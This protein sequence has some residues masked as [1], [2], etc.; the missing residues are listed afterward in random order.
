VVEPLCFSVTQR[1]IRP[2]LAGYCQKLPPSLFPARGARYSQFYMNACRVI[3]LQAHPASPRRAYSRPMIDL[4]SVAGLHAHG[5]QLA[6]Y[7]P[8][9]DAW[10][11]LPLD[12]MVAQGKGSLRLPLRVRCRDCGEF[13][14]LQVRPP[15]PAHPRSTGWME[16]TARGPSGVR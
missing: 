15:M 6:A 7:C 4:G 1:T 13:G 8:R 11:V 16:T 10:R 9:C 5:H 2:D 12:A 14:R 3:G